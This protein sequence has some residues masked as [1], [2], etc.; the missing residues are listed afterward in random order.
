MLLSADSA[1]LGVWRD[2]EMVRHKCLTGYTVRRKAGIAQL[3]Y[4]RR[5]A[6]EQPILMH[7][8]LP[9]RNVHPCVGGALQ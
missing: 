3:T 1:A 9:L 6:S 7:Y 8:L 5:C 2:G 4:L